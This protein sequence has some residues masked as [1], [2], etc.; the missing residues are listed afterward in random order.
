[1]R[2]ERFHHPSRFQ[3]VVSGRHRN[4]AHCKTCASAKASFLGGF[5]LVPK[6]CRESCFPLPSMLWVFLVVHWNLILG[7]IDFFSRNQ[8]RSSDDQF[9]D[10]PR[11]ST[12][13]KQHQTTDPYNPYRARPCFP[14][15]AVD[16]S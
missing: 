9:W 14:M 13:P 2:D 7:R 5:L 15:S 4:S 1:M 3:H 8:L 11:V 12:T 6:G 10:R 16:F